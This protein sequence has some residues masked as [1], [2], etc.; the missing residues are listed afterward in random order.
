MITEITL[1]IVVLPLLCLAA[2]MFVIALMALFDGE[3]LCALGALL[4]ALLAAA[5]AA[6]IVSSDYGSTEETITIA[7]MSP[8]DR[9]IEGSEYVATVTL[10]DA[11][12]RIY[13]TEK[14]GMEVN[15]TYSCIVTEDNEI[16][17]WYE[18]LQ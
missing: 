1:F 3:P 2:A 15:H 10:W 6:A 18:V 8:V 12:G 4:L 11:A 7:G 9:T 17:D 14:I 16:L 13:T 5:G